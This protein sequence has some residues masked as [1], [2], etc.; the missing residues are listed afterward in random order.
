MSDTPG[1]WLGEE[2]ETDARL[3]AAAP[4][5]LDAL[6]RILTLSDLEMRDGDEAR[7]IAHDAIAKAEGK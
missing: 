5:L 2:V 4:D 7:A 3:I 1:S 6:K